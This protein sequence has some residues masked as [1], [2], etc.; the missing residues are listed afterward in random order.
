[1]TK[2]DKVDVGGG[3]ANCRD[4]MIKRLSSKNLNGVADYLTLKTRLAF[5]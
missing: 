4:K 3:N 1:M 2:D 5:F